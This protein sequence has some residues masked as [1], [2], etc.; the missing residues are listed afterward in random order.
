MQRTPPPN[1]P[2]R[3]SLAI[4]KTLPDASKADLPPKP[5]TTPTSLSPTTLHFPQAALTPSPSPKRTS[6]GQNRTWPRPIGSVVV[7]LQITPT[8]VRTKNVHSNGGISHSV[9]EFKAAG[10]IVKASRMN[11]GSFASTSRSNSNN[12]ISNG[13]HHNHLYPNGRN[14]HQGLKKMNKLEALQIELQLIHNKLL[15]GAT[16]LTAREQDFLRRQMDDNPTRIPTLMMKLL[17]NQVL[18]KTYDLLYGMMHWADRRCEHHLLEDLLMDRLY[19]FDV[20]ETF[21]EGLMSIREVSDLMDCQIVL[22]CVRNERAEDVLKEQAKCD[23]GE[24]QYGSD[25]GSLDMDL[26]DDD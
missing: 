1:L 20:E 21:I 7:S 18:N 4:Y 24:D 26:S 9:G 14:M 16:A 6:Y 3:P 11:H 19:N 13:I 12:N 8:L 2:P 15:G 23:V 10:R 17:I 22:Q 25:T 5:P